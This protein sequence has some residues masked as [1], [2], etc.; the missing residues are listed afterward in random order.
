MP[1]KISKYR[2]LDGLEFNTYDEAY[3]H[4]AC[5]KVVEDVRAAITDTI[6]HTKDESNRKVY[7]L[8]QAAIMSF[9][10]MLVMTELFTQLKTIIKR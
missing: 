8:E 7:I 2:T 1:T 5:L 3:Q 10:D 6:S 9:A 4:E